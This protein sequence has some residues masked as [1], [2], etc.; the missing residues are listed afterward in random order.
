MKAHVIITAL[1]FAL[2]YFSFDEETRAEEAQ[3]YEQYIAWHKQA[4]GR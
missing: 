4:L 1:L 3:K 2:W